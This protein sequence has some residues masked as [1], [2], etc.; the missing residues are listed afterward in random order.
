MS[1]VLW[2]LW[3][4]SMSEGSVAVN[5]YVQHL[6][7]GDHAAAYGM[8]TAEKRGK[9]SLEE[10]KSTMHTDRLADVQGISI[11]GARSLNPGGTCLYTNLD[12]ASHPDSGPYGYYI[13]Y[14]KKDGGSLRVHDVLTYTSI[15]GGML[16]STEFDESR[17]PFPCHS[18]GL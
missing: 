17:E 12:F 4:C 13:F 7:G 1:W 6:H 5:E 2:A 10:W 8:V 18:N 14:L 3:G 16:K 9:L 11:R 15:S